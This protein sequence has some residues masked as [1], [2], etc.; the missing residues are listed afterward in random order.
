MDSGGVGQGFLLV[1]ISVI[2][3][4]QKLTLN[5]S[6]VLTLYFPCLPV[7]HFRHWTSTTFLNLKLTFETVLFSLSL[8]FYVTCYVT[9]D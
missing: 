4:M 5:G 2:L 9:A 8:A 6:C 7:T 3:G 1:T